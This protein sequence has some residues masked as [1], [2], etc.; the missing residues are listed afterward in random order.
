MKEFG[1]WASLGPLLGPANVKLCS[2]GVK[3][4]ANVKTFI[5]VWQLFF[6]L[7]RFRLV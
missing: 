6:D 4:N 2:D 5:D 3:A 1:P 7:F